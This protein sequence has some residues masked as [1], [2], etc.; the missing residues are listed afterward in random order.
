MRVFHRLTFYVVDV[1][2]MDCIYLG[3]KVCSF[4]NPWWLMVT[5][6]LAWFSVRKAPCTF[7]IILIDPVLKRFSPGFQSYDDWWVCA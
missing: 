6:F 5:W 1:V 7:F 2:R 4:L 3:Q